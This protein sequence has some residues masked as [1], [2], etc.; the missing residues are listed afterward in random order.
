ML[1]EYQIQ[2]LTSKIEI[3]EYGPYIE[4]RKVVFSGITSG[5]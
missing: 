4:D 5:S 2:F 1:K 3:Q